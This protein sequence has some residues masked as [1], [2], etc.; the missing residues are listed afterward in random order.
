MAHHDQS[1]IGQQQ[2]AGLFAL[3]SLIKNDCSSNNNFSWPDLQLADYSSAFGAVTECC[4]VCSCSQ[5]Q[6]Q[7]T[8]EA[9]AICVI[10]P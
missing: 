5:P 9:A 1:F 10:N 8:G 7:T 2:P 6:Q 4:S 3:P